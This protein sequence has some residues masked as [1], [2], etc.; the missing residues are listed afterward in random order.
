M[1]PA[2]TVKEAAAQ[3]GISVGRVHQ[4]IHSG[5]LSAEKSG[6]SGS[7]TTAMLRKGQNA[8]PGEEDRRLNRLQTPDAIS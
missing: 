6:A 7:S 5:A 8:S 1:T 2:I 3:L 4:L